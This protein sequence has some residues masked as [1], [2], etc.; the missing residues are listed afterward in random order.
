HYFVDCI[1]LDRL[2]LYCF[3]FSSRRWHTILSRDWSSDV[4][5]SDLWSQPTA[6]R[7]APSAGTTRTSPLPRHTADNATPTVER[8]SCRR[9]HK[10]GRAS[11]RERAMTCA[12]GRSFI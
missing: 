11:C 12:R 6:R 3:F 5:S 7:V 9:Q 1:S 8:Q 2:R 10:I 4:C